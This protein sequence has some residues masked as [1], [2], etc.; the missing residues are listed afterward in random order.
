MVPLLVHLHSL[1]TWALVQIYQLPKVMFQKLAVIYSANVMAKK[2]YSFGPWSS[3]PGIGQTWTGL[4]QDR[5][6]SFRT[7][8]CSQ[9]C[10]WFE[11]YT[12]VVQW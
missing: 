3:P 12:V 9:M 10:K 7:E 5:R 11:R 8:N 4:V 2:F 1:D 6:N